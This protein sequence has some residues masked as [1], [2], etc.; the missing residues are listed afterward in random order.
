MHTCVCNCIINLCGS[1]FWIAGVIHQFILIV[2]LQAILV[3]NLGADAQVQ[4]SNGSEFVSFRVAHNDRWK[5]DN[6]QVHDQTYWVDCTLNGRPAVLEYLRA[7]TQVFVMGTLSAR[8]YSSAKDRCMKAGLS[9]RVQR[10]ELLGGQTDIIP[11]QLVDESGALH[12]VTKYF[13]TDVTGCVL[14]STRGQ[15]FAV[16]DNGWVVPYEQAQQEIAE[17]EKDKPHGKK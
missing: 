13:H 10:V 15:Q 6:G 3:G 9:I 8:V 5:D 16:D 4:N 17:A 14:S 11:R 2:M 1:P 7:G 12:D